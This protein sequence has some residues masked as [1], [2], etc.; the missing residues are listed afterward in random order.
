MTMPWLLV[1]ARTSWYGPVRIGGAVLAA[2]GWA[3]DQLGPSG[4]WALVGLA[5]LA[6]LG[7]IRTT[8]QGHAHASKPTGPET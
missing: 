2:F 3:G 1:L 5:G 8:L 7:A 6:V 4:P